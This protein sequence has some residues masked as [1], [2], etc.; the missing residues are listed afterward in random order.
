MAEMEAPPKLWTCPVS[1][2]SGRY[3]YEVGGIQADGWKF[4]GG[5]DEPCRFSM[6]K[7]GLREKMETAEIYYA[8]FEA[9]RNERG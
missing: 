6:A 3:E 8:G 2:C 1:M 5:C 4:A 7:D 9:G